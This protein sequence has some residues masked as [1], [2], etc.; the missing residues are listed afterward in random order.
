M[1][2]FAKPG[3]AY[4]V[5]LGI[6]DQPASLGTSKMQFS[7]E[8]GDCSVFPGVE[9]FAC[10]GALTPEEVGFFRRFL[11]HFKTEPKP[12]TKEEPMD[13][14]QYAA[15]MER[16]GKLE[17]AV[18]AF[19]AGHERQRGEPAKASPEAAAPD[20]FSAL[21]GKVDELAAGF[22]ALVSRLEA[23]RPGIA[24]PDTTTPADDAAIL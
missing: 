21:M 14:E 11:A 1:E 22:S 18:G 12:E 13:K 15:L 5:G 7:A 20:Q 17:E 10:G 16:I 8:A 23:A 24:I 9:L 19:A 4:L 6:T 3:K 2:D